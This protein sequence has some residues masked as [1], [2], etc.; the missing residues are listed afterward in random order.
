MTTFNMMNTSRESLEKEVAKINRK[1]SKRN[2]PEVVVSYSDTKNSPVFENGKLVAYYETVD[3]T[4][5][6]AAPKVEGFKVIGILDQKEGIFHMFETPEG[7]DFDHFLNR[8][9]C[10]HCHKKINRNSYVFLLNERTEEI[11]QIGTKCVNEYTGT[12]N[13]DKISD[14]FEFINTVSTRMESNQ[15]ETEHHSRESFVFPNEIIVEIA[16]PIIKKY[17]YQK[18]S[19]MDSTVNKIYA[20]IRSTGLVAA[21]TGVYNKFVNYV[22]SLD[23]NYS[24]FNRNLKQIVKNTFVT[25]KTI[26]YL[27]AAVNMYIKSIKTESVK[28]ESNFIDTVGEKLQN[29]E[30]TYT[31]MTSYETHFSYNGE[32][33][34][35]FFFEDKNGNKLNWFSS[36]SCDFETGATLI[37]KSAIVKDQKNYKGENITYIK[38]VRF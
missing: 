2:L 4:I 28:V 7:F 8:S 17:G 5:N 33:N 21:S 3:V 34:H 20:E 22:N 10:D 30:V 23:S 19:E 32:I 15:N 12:D 1:L 26:G 6:G 29:I 14:M 16:L 35:I 36:K 37:I 18:T 25:T 13:L 38:N 24:E 11:L 9:I 27:A 31:G